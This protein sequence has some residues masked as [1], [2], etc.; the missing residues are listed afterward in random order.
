[1]LRKDPYAITHERRKREGRDERQS[2]CTAAVG[3][4]RGAPA[5]STATQ[6]L[7]VKIMW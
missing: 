2:R 4:G 6:E 7:R 3:T 5:A 1:L